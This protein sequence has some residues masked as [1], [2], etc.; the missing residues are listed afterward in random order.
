MGIS[1]GLLGGMN[2]IGQQNIEQNLGQQQINLQKKDWAD[3]LSQVMGSVGNLAGGV[4][5]AALCWIAREIYGEQNPKWKL[6]RTWLITKAPKWF[7]KF[8]IKFGPRI[9]TF[10]S[11]KPL[12]KAVVRK[13]MDKR[14][15]QLNEQDMKDFNTSSLLKSLQMIL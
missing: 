12:L 2:T 7:F 6:F 9:A 3:Y 8:Y 14:I 15:C 5:G 1:Q 11:N 4:A 13:W 10:I